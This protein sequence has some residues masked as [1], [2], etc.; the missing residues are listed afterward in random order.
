M[1][2]PSRLTRRSNSV[3]QRNALPPDLHEYELLG[4]RTK[5]IKSSA[6]TGQRSHEE[7][8]KRRPIPGTL[9]LFVGVFLAALSLYTVVIWRYEVKQERQRKIVLMAEEHMREFM[10]IKPPPGLETVAVGKRKFLVNDWK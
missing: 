2:Y 10:G 4:E 6:N 9:K 8:H 5:K 3:S 7:T 1:P